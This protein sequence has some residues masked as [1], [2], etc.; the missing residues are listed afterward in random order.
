MASSS[1]NGWRTSSCW[2]EKAAAAAANPVWTCLTL[3]AMLC[4]CCCLTSDC[5]HRWAF[6]ARA[7][8]VQVCVGGGRESSSKPGLDLSD[9][10]RDAVRVL[11]LGKRLRTHCG[12]HMLAL[13]TA[14][15]VGDSRATITNAISSHLRPGIDALQQCC[16]QVIMALTED[17]KLRVPEVMSVLRLVQDDI[18]PNKLIQVRDPCFSLL[19]QAWEMRVHKI[20]RLLE[21]MEV[22]NLLHHSVAHFLLSGVAKWEA[23]R[24]FPF[25]PWAHCG[26]PPPNHPY[27]IHIVMHDRR[28]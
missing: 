7:L 17:N 12:P 8:Y 27:H 2:P 11:L 18:Q 28:G 26:A 25:L 10:V 14:A 22:L 6:H 23:N 24:P 20:L 1:G 19:Q 21:S 4:G 15:Q 9:T 16:S 5:G 3:Y 13:N